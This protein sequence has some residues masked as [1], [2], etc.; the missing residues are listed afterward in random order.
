MGRH[1]AQSDNLIKPLILSNMNS[2]RKLSNES[3]KY[4]SVMIGNEKF[5]GYTI[6]NLPN[7]FG[8]RMNGESEGIDTWTKIPGTGLTYIS[9]SHFNKGW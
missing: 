7:R 3:D 6:G 8:Y 5:R 4:K 1:D 9:E 2:F